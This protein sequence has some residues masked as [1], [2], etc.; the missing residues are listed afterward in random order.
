MGNGVKTMQPTAMRPRRQRSY[1]SR[2]RTLIAL[3]MTTGAAGLAGGVLLAAVPDGSLLHADLG[4]LAGTPFS[5]WR[6]PGVLLT[7]LVGG[8]LLLTGW[9]QWR[10]H[11]YARELS[12]FAGI[13][14]IAFEFAELAW[15][16]FQPLQVLFTLVGLAIIGLAWSTRPSH[17]RRSLRHIVS[18]LGDV[19]HDMPAFLTAPLYRRWHLHWGATRAE[20]ATSL[21]GD[22]LQSRAQYRSTRAITIDA[23]PDAVWPWLVQVGCQRAGFYSND[24]LDNL[25]RPSATTIMP[26]LQR[27]E[28]GQWVP[29][30]PAATPTDRTAF[31]VHSFEPGKWLLW[32]K[33]DSTWAWQ[34]TATD[35]GGTRLVTRIRAVYDWRDP[36]MALL[37]VLLMEFGDFAMLRRMLRGIKAR[38]ESVVRDPQPHGR[39]S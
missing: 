21:P 10:D 25:G 31:K 29:M 4:A 22:A 28:V 16:G 32:A 39:P 20:A 36:P 13:G 5:D 14:L 33:P 34:L 7:A 17:P 23:P 19:L 30:S 6:V 12:I 11:P 37:S 15:I 1:R 38:A 27:L 8:G 2:R 24:L 18:E 26:S 9:W 3:E 35:D